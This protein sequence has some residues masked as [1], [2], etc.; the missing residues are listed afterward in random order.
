M[1]HKDRNASDPYNIVFT[2]QA[3]K[4]TMMVAQIKEQCPP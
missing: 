4:N 2:L 3:H 1:T